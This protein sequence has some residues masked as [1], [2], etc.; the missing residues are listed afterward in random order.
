MVFLPPCT[1]YTII[2]IF[3]CLRYIST[4]SCKIPACKGNFFLW[5]KNHHIFTRLSSG[6]R[7]NILALSCILGKGRSIFMQRIFILKYNLKITAWILVLLMGLLFS[8][9]GE[10]EK[11]FSSVPRNLTIDEVVKKVGPSV[12]NIEA[13]GA[14]RGS[15]VILSK[16]GYILTNDH[17]I[18]GA[19]SLEIHLADKRTLKAKLI[20][21]DSRRDVAVIKVESN[22]LQEAVFADSGE[23]KIG[24]D[25]IAIGN[26]KG[27]ENSVTKGII[28]NLDIDVDNGTNIRK[29]LQ[30]D[31]PVNPGNSGGAL[32]NMRGEVI[33]I[34]EMGRRDA[35]SMNY[36]I[37]SKDAREIAEQLID[38]GYVS[39]PYLGVSTVNQKIEKESYIFV[40]SVMDNSPADKEG[41]RKNDVIVKVNDVRVETVSKLR[42]QLNNSGIGSVVSLYIVRNTKQGIQKGTIQV[43][44]EELPKGY[45]TI[46]WS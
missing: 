3:R 39:Y 37:P 22:D 42:E 35:E 33:G 46:D 45:Y 26:A 16:D 19:N 24:E 34:N 12:V 29:C 38:K 4:L 36:A 13:K 15:G 44:L 25:V 2:R 1:Y 23:V 9:C 10:D 8:G 7:G 43:K 6:I 17:V 21:T 30:T 32:V 18:R 11:N 27:V 5:K 14:G 40:R 31:A 28:S 41:L 20:G